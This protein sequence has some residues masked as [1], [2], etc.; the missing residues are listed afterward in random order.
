MHIVINI[1]TTGTLLHIL[2][3]CNQVLMCYM[4]SEGFLRSAG[5]LQ[6]KKIDLYYFQLT[7]VVSVLLLLRIKRTEFYILESDATRVFRAAFQPLDS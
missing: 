7:C 4:T 3:S 6:Q 5:G 2:G 1:S